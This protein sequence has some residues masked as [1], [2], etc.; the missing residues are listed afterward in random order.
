MESAHV[1]TSEL[2]VIRFLYTVFEAEFENDFLE[3]CCW[4]MQLSFVTG[5]FGIF[6]IRVL[7]RMCLFSC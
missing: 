6:K 7:N 2:S 4:R 5:E 3:L 1:N